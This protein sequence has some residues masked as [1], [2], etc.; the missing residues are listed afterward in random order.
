MCLAIEPM[1]ALGSRKIRYWDDGWL[2]T[3]RDGS[4][5]AHF[6]KSVAITEEGPLILTAEEGYERPVG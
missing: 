1:F 2:I 5:A 6:E 3:T 4:W